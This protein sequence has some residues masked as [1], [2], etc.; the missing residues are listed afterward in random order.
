MIARS[1]LLVLAFAAL[2]A[3]TI[4]ATA[5]RR[6]THERHT[7][8]WLGVCA[9][10]A[11]LALWRQAID[12]LAAAMGIY[13]PPAA[14]FFLCCVGL[15]GLVFRL[16]LQVATQREQLR[17]LAQE[18]ALLNAQPPEAEASSRIEALPRA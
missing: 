8:V 12:V 17:K 18:V 2:F 9:V 15:L 5:R 6:R 14:L 1:S 4:V 7:L 10:I 13:Y 16:S 3:L 11:G